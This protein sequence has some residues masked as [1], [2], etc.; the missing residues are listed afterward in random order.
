MTSAVP[1]NL[2]RPMLSTL[3]TD[4]VRQVMWRF[5]DRADL[6]QLVASAR[7]VA[8]QTVAQLV[9]HGGRETQDWTADKQGMLEAFDQAGI[10]GRFA[11]GGDGT[12]A[13]GA[14]NLTAALAA[15]ELAWVD[16][17]A[18]ACSSALRLAQEP[19]AESGTGEQQDRY[20]AHGRSG[21]P[22][23]TAPPL[24]GA[25]C[26]TEPLPFAGVETGTLSGRVRIAQWQEG[27]EPLLEVQKRGRYTTNMD[28]ANYVVATVASDDPRIQGTCMVILEEGDPGVFDR[29]PAVPV[30]AHQLASTR[31]P[32]FSVQVPASRILGGYAIRDGVLIP[33]ASHLKILHPVLARTRIGV[34]VATAAKLLSAIEPVLRYQ[35]ER[36]R[37]AGGTT[38][39]AAEIGLQTH[40]DVLHRLID[41]W[42]AGEAAASFGF[43]AARYFDAY[44]ALSRQLDD[45]RQAEGVQTPEDKRSAR[46][47]ATRMALEYLQLRD[48]GE[49]RDPQRFEALR[50]NRLVQ[51]LL[52]EATIHVFSPACKVW[53]T[54]RG[55]SMLR[56]AVGLMGGQGITAACPGF[57]PNKWLDAQLE[58]MYE[59]PESV[60]RRQ[61]VVA[62]TNELFLAQLQSWTNELR[63]LAV[64]RPGTGACTLASAMELWSWTL[65]HLQEAKDSAGKP[66]F[67]DKR[68]GATFAMADALCWILAAHCQILDVLQIAGPASQGASY[69]ESA[70]AENIAPD[71]ASGELAGF[72]SFFTDLCHVQTATAAGEVGRICT[73]LVF[74]YQEHPSWE[75]D[76]GNC[77]QGDEIDALEGVMPGISVGARITGDVLEA[78]GSHANKAG[79]CVRFAGLYEFMRRRSKLDGCLTGAR[80]AKDRAARDLTVVKIP[81]SLDYPPPPTS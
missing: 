51:H 20:L 44:D 50:S 58:S 12:P 18:A 72:L 40:E 63:R 37:G 43:A 73:E 52:L 69:P 45:A 21:A 49:T 78:D 70:A 26:L 4:V 24:R 47:Q 36:F 41:V 8:R 15:F 14:A 68:Q 35:R 81:D 10:T 61:L 9:A 23:G 30:I 6:Q 53:N 31:N 19:I 33:N 39:E 60:H 27:Q 29:G 13:A 16:G 80:V 11:D 17:G 22:A 42:T 57:L 62:M 59:G 71:Q 3:P 76:C 66:I 25:F 46:Q 77:Y 5:A 65:R 75:A 54:T 79:P 34:G 64:T 7:Q 28:F 32:T 2:P 1:L 55:A 48:N 38:A 74:G 56:E 67:R